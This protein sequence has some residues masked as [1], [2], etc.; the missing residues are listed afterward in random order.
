MQVVDRKGNLVTKGEN[1]NHTLR[2]LYG[3]F[4]GRCALK[5]LTCKWITNIGG[6]YMNT[7][8]SCRRIAPFI[9]ENQIDMHIYEERA[10]VSYNDFF[11]RKIRPGE[12]PFDMSEDALITPAD[13]KLTY[14]EI[15][16]DTI[17][18]IKDTKYK[19]KDLLNNESIAKEYHGGICLIF[20]LTVDDYHRYH[21]ID[22][23]RVVSNTYIPGKFHTVNPIANDYYPIYKQNAREYT[24]LETKNFGQIIQMEIGAMMVGK[25]VNLPCQ[26]FVKGQEKGMFEFGGSTVVILIKKDIVDIDVDIINNSKE[27]KETVVLLGETIG[28]KKRGDK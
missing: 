26:T 23:G 6:W 11:T 13:S 5:V 16:E 28:R 9:S 3:T 18:T 15:D 2:R 14:Y 21:Y 1:Q 17:L 4:L 20:R 8:L 22:D 25:I 10:F 7:H 27:D 19:I 24:V 12:R